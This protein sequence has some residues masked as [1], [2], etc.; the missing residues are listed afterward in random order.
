NSAFFLLPI[1]YVHNGAKAFYKHKKHSIHFTDNH[2]KQNEMNDYS[3][4]VNESSFTDVI[5]ENL[6]NLNV[7]NNNAENLN[8]ENNNAENLN[9]ENDND[10]LP[11]DNSKNTSHHLPS[12]H[13]ELYCEK[14]FETWDKCQEDCEQSGKYTPY[15]STLPEKQRNKGSKRINCPFLVNTSKNKSYGDEMVIKLKSM[16]LEHNH[17]LVP[18]NAA[19]A[20]EYRKLTT[21]IKELIK[22][23]TLCDVDIPNHEMEGSDAAKLLQHFEKE[24]SKDPDCIFAVVDN[25]FKSQI[26][27]Q[28][29]LLDETSKSYRWVLQQTIKATEVQPNAFIINADLGLESVVS[30]IFQTPTFFIVFGILDAILK[31]NCP[32]LLAFERYWQQIMIDFPESTEYLLRQL[33]TCKTTWAKAFTG[34]VFTAE[35]I[36]TQWSESINSIIKRMKYVTPKILQLHI[37][38]MNKAVLY[39]SKKVALD[40]LYNLTLDM[41][42]N[43]LI[44]VEYD[45][46]QIH[47]EE[48]LEK[49]DHSLIAEIWKVHSIENKLN[50]G[51]YVVLLKNGFHLCTCILLFD[52][53]IVCHHWF[54]VILQSEKGLFHISLIPNSAAKA[55]G[56]KHFIKGLLLKLAHK[57]VELV[58]YDDPNDPDPQNTEDDQASEYEQV[59]NEVLECDLAMED[60]QLTEGDQVIEH[61]QTSYLDVQRHVGKGHP[62]KK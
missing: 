35:I 47:F 45:L 38:Q 27:A 60:D 42:E 43:G 4:I 5:S 24:H 10:E 25:N 8:I 62:A 36:S 56:R 46:H 1:I 30:E 53:R 23:Y 7:E 39:N 52:S 17:T 22:S 57:C 2:P 16:C 26:V 48:L 34:Q 49:I 58:D 33:D 41:V 32:N 61:A 9:V 6:K 3:L 54:Y 13:I 59:D 12:V 44:E 21:E 50:I 29:V 55:N 15:K 11:T 40:N 37:D 19:F 31:N 14:T 18:E 28:A 20:T 51:Q